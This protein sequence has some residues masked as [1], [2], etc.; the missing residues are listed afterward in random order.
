MKTN[1][2]HFLF[3]QLWATT[4]DLLPDGLILRSTFTDQEI[5]T[6]KFE[7]LFP[8]VALSTV[9]LISSK[10]AQ[11][12]IIIPLYHLSDHPI[13]RAFEIMLFTF[14][15]SSIPEN[16]VSTHITK[17][18]P[19]SEEIK[20][21]PL[22]WSELEETQGS[23]DDFIDQIKSL[24]DNYP[25]SFVF[26]QLEPWRKALEKVQGGNPITQAD[27]ELAQSLF[28]EFI[29]NDKENIK[30]TFEGAFYCVMN[31]Y[32]AALVKKLLNNSSDK[33]KVGINK[34]ITLYVDIK[35]ID[36]G[37]DYTEEEAAESLNIYD[38]HWITKS[39]DLV[40]YAVTEDFESRS[41]VECTIKLKGDFFVFPNNSENIKRVDTQEMIRVV[42]MHRL[43]QGDV[44]DLLRSIAN[45]QD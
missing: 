25:D 5:K 28:E 40:L 17:E 16:Y 22:K 1:I 18:E 29:K 33:V 45:F 13:E 15:L 38:G 32:R 39:N 10:L 24:E 37:S 41:A 19:V 7:D 30:N 11:S 8:E 6:K 34:D 2:I 44:D 9:G 3:D 23:G 31:D 14:D 35:P 43:S 42:P 12:G 20:F 27:E 36:F 4:R 21:K 26:G